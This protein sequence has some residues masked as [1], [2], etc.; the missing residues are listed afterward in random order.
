MGRRHITITNSCFY[1][2]SASFS[3][4]HF[5]LVL[6]GK[7]KEKSYLYQHIH[8]SSFLIVNVV[9]TKEFRTNF[10]GAYA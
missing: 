8:Y 1:P 5:I 4:A 9:R 10:L 6:Q 2:N 7:R 3:S